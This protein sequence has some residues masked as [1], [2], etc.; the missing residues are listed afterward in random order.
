MKKGTEAMGIWVQVRMQASKEDAAITVSKTG[1]SFR[2]SSRDQA[3][4]EMDM[5]ATF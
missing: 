5:K 1:F 4:H 2:F 3:S